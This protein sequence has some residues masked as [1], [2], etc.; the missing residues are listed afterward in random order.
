MEILLFLLLSEQESPF[1]YVL[2]ISYNITLRYYSKDCIYPNP[3]LLCKLY[4]LF[5]TL[6]RLET[7]TNGSIAIK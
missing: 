4:Y 5:S 1:P 3:T 6:Y 2:M 7:N